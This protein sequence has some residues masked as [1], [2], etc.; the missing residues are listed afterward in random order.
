MIHGHTSNFEYYSENLKWHARIDIVC[1][2]LNS[3]SCI[4]SVSCYYGNIF[5]LTDSYSKKVVCLQK[6]LYAG[7]SGLK[8]VHPEVTSV[9]SHHLCL[10]ITEIMLR[11]ATVAPSPSWSRGYAVQTLRFNY[12]AICAL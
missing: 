5:W 7:F 6:R 11:R 2:S 3:L 10:T 1:K 12:R 8:N 9:T 4:F